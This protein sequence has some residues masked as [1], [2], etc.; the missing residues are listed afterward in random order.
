M[1]QEKDEH[2][3]TENCLYTTL[4]H[5]CL[6]TTLSHNCLYTTLS[7]NYSR[8]LWQPGKTTESVYTW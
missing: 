4:S 1:S 6:Y 7:R 2:Q 5:N 3:Y 8:I